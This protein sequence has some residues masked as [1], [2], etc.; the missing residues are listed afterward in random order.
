MAD[1]KAGLTASPKVQLSAGLSGWQMAKSKAGL[2]VDLSA[3]LWESLMVDC[4]V[5]PWVALKVGQLGD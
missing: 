5:A 4:L 3:D 1:V 2:W